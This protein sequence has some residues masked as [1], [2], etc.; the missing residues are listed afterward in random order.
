MKNP[1]WVVPTIVVEDDTLARRALRRIEPS[2]ITS[3]LTTP[4]VTTRLS[5][6]DGSTK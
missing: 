2:L 5:P 4:L 6:S 3:T 1:K